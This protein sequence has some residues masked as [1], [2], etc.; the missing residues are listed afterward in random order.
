MTSTGN[1][2]TPKSAQPAM[3]AATL[4]TL[5][6]AA[7]Y[8]R[9]TTLRAAVA[10][11][12]EETVRLWRKTLRHSASM[13]EAR[14][15]AHYLA[16]RRR[17]LSALQPALAAYGLSSLGR[18]DAHVLPA[19]DALIATLGRLAGL[20]APSYPQAT[21]MTAGKTAL[22][23]RQDSFFG[24]YPDAPRTRIMATLPSE[25][26][27]DPGLAYRLIEAGM[28]CARINCAH[29]GPDVWKAM[30][31]HVR[32]GA[33]QL[34]RDCRVMM[35]L[36][37]PKCRIET[38]YVNGYMR[39]RRGDRFALVR[40]LRYGKPTDAAVATISFPKII[41]RLKT[42]T[43]AWIDDGKIGA[44][45][46]SGTA[47]RAVLEVFSAPLKGERL[48][49]GKGVNFPQM[50][51]DLPPL[52]AT[53]LKALDFIARHADLVAFSFVQRPADVVRLDREINRRRTQ[54]A[55]LPLVLKI[56]TPT[57][58]QN[59]PQLI[60]TAAATRPVAVMIARGDL[61]VELGF[62]RLSEIQEEMLWLC[63]AAHVPVI[64]ATQVLDNLVAEG[65]PSRAEAT[66]AAMAQRAECVMLNKGPYLVEGVAF[67]KDIL[68]RMDRHQDKK[69]A[70]LDKLKSWRDL[71][72][73]L[74]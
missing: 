69:F 74:D 44:R 51:L 48:K 5:S 17:N 2:S 68:R 53:D 72:I 65:R 60:V 73:D 3:G 10:R 29:D 54:G 71:A 20:A 15:L 33:K 63:D 47:D 35:D 64:W 38:I 62:A 21:A 41:G 30:I 16:L 50:K 52:G 42:G 7:L 24:R 49:P 39:F 9:L 37:G 45:V 14:N 43:E 56:E 34:G 4:G 46:I 22:R 67:L 6:P 58:V 28:N 19:L 12:G 66:D 11:D 32:A 55:P 26:A 23:E 18:S 59:L 25:A 36:A 27:S 70:R 13:P 8:R 57:A 61:A 1:R 31:A 40:K